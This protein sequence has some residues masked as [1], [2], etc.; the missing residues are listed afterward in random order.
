MNRDERIEHYLN[1]ATRCEHA[2]ERVREPFAQQTFME[3]ANHWRDLARTARQ[4]Q[5]LNDRRT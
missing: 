5:R 4:L 1:N 3:A 2:A